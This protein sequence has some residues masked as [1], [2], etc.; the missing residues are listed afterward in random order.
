MVCGAVSVIEICLREF[1]TFLFRR[2]III[3]GNDIVNLQKRLCE[4]ALFLLY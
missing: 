3:N 2:T 4:C 1:Q